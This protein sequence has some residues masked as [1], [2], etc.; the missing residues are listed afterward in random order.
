MR[1]PQDFT[2]NAITPK[3]YCDVVSVMLPGFANTHNKCI[4]PN[5]LGV[6]CVKVQRFLSMP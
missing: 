6:V 5:A 1:A 4:Y 2:Q 3:V